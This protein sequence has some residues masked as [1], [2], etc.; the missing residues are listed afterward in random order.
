MTEIGGTFR[1]ESQPGS[2][3]KIILRLPWPELN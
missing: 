2:G 1:L 3:T